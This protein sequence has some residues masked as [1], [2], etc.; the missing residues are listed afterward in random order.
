MILD[1]LENRELYKEIHAGINKALLYIQSTDFL[2]I[3]DG[4]YE[5]EGED[6]FAILKEYETKNKE[7]SLLESHLKYIDIHYI[8]EGAEQ[9][10]VTTLVNQ[11]PKKEYDAVDDYMLFLEPYDLI[12]LKKGMFAVFFPDDIHMPEIKLDSIA[13]VKKV[14]VKVK[15][16]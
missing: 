8:V 13:I 15:L 1:K 6:V 2:N 3:P 11:K 5:I 10:G 4:K 16:L 14:V 7:D 12:T 9:I